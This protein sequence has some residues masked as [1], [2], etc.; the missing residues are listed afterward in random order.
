MQLYFVD[1]NPD[2]LPNVHALQFH[3]AACLIWR[4][5]GGAEPEDYDTDSDDEEL[6]PVAAGEPS[7][8]A[9][10]RAEESS[11]TLFDQGA[12]AR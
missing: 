11:M 8:I 2:T 12:E 1:N 3:K 5:A 10:L 7:K 9:E 6:P 4:M